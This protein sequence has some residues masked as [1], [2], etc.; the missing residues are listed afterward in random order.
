MVSRTENYVIVVLDDD[1]L[2]RA[3]AIARE[4]GGEV[5]ELIVDAVRECVERVEIDNQ[6]A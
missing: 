3:K 4:E 1:L 2:A 6:R 5:E